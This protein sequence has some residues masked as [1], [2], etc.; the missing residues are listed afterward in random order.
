MARTQNSRRVANARRRNLRTDC[1][2][3]PSE[4]AA[5]AQPDLED[6]LAQ[7]SRPDGFNRFLHRTYDHHEGT[8]RVHRVGAPPSRG[9]ALRC[10]R[11]SLRSLDVPADCRSLCGSECSAISPPRPGLRLRQRSWFADRITR[12]GTSAHRAPESLAESVRGTP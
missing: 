9:A 12:D 3:H 8:I 5:T 11:A 4:T 1:L 2:S 7:S 6:L 10:D